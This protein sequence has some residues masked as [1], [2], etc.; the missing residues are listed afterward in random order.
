MRFLRKKAAGK[1]GSEKY[2]ALQEIRKENPGFNVLVKQTKKSKTS[3]KGLYKGLT[4]SFM[5]RYISVHDESGTIRNEYERKR[6]ICSDPIANDPV[7]S[8]YQEMKEWFL[9][10]YPA[11]SEFYNGR[12]SA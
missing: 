6:C 12:K 1:V 7:A 11:I 10:Q 3:S 5:E 9:N 8:S 2:N 4:Y